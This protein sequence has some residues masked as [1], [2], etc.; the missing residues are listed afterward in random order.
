[1]N[2][3][4][5]DIFKQILQ[6]HPQQQI[7]QQSNMHFAP[8][9]IALIKYWGKSNENLN[10]AMTPSLSIS[11]NHLGT[12]T[13]IFIS[14][15]NELIFNNRKI[16]NNAFFKRTF[17]FINL[18]Q[19]AL[20][21]HCKMKIITENNI[22]TASG[23]A[24]SASGFASLTLTLNDFFSLNLSPNELSTLAR[25]GSGSAC[26]SILKNSRFAVWNGDFAEPFNFSN[27]TKII[28]DN[29]RI[30]I[31]ILDEN[32]K[33][34]SSREAMQQTKTT[35]Q[36]GEN[37]DYDVWLKQTKQDFLKIQNATTWQ[38]FGEIV[39]RNSLLM[40]RAIRTA[41]INY[42]N[43]KTNMII[44]FVEKCRMNNLFIY[45]TIDAGANVAL[46]YQ[47]NDADD[48]KNALS[49][50]E[51]EIKIKFKKLVF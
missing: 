27:P 38:E 49:K 35:W 48:I 1:M 43:N 22:P 34:I 37:Y 9:N 23:L 20:N 7:K 10:L 25:L 16:E 17:D 32:H 28:A 19:K 6:K 5:I 4:K 30:M 46:L 8:I 18:W 47:N 39:E 51:S 41:G 24:S 44:E 11:S 21:L 31:I 14:N 26:R 29:M 45:T 40:H 50:F 15:N 12:N 36:N 42:F 13:Q 33:K 2:L 3:N